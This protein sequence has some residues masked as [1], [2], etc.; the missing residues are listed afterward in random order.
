MP[1]KNPIQ[2]DNSQAG[3]LAAISTLEYVK[4]EIDGVSVVATFCVAMAIDD[5][6]KCALEGPDERIR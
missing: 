3:I 2:I 4:E 5:L 1:K 6:R